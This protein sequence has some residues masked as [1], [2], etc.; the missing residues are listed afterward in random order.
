V[1]INSERVMWWWGGEIVFVASAPQ[2]GR[3]K[4]V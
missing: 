4:L 3:N 2:C 1:D